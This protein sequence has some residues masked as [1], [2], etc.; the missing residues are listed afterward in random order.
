MLNLKLPLC[1]LQGRASA[2]K[3]CP[4]PG[5]SCHAA[6]AKSMQALGRLMHQ[7]EL[8]LQ[9]SVER[10][11]QHRMATSGSKSPGW[12]RLAQ[13]EE[14][15]PPERAFSQGACIRGGGT[16]IRAGMEPLDLLPLL[17]AEQVQ[18]QVGQEQPASAGPASGLLA[19]DGVVV[20]VRRQAWPTSPLRAFIPGL[21][22]G[23]TT[24]LDTQHSH[25]EA[26]TVTT[27]TWHGGLATASPPH[28]PASP[29]APPQLAPPLGPGSAPPGL[30]AQ[31]AGDALEPQ[32]AIGTEAAAA[33]P[34]V[35]PSPGHASGCMPSEPG[36]EERALEEA[37]ASAASTLTASSG[38]AGDGSCDVSR[39]C[40]CSSSGC[41]CCCRGLGEGAWA[42]SC[43]EDGSSY[44]A[45]SSGHAEG[46]SPGAPGPHASADGAR[47]RGWWQQRGVA[48][49]QAVAIVAALLLAHH[50][51]SLPAPE[52]G[53]SAWAGTCA[54]PTP[55]TWLCPLAPAQA[56]CCSVA[57]ARTHASHLYLPDTLS[58]CDCRSVGGSR[59]GVASRAA[60]YG[61]RSSC[62]LRAAH[63]AAEPSGSCVQA[64]ERLRCS[65]QG[66]LVLLTGPAE[67]RLPPH[68]PSSSSAPFLGRRPSSSLTCAAIQGLLP[69]C[70][71]DGPHAGRQAQL[72]MGPDAQPPFLLPVCPLS[73]W[74]RRATC[75]GP[76]PPSP[77][78][79]GAV[80]SAIMARAEGTQQA[81]G[82]GRPKEADG[83]ARGAGAG[84]CPLAAAV[85][86]WESAASLRSPGVSRH[87]AWKVRD[88]QFSGLEPCQPL[89]SPG[90][91]QP[92]VLQ[93]AL[94]TT[95]APVATEGPRL[96]VSGAAG[97]RRF[98]CQAGV[99]AFMQAAPPPK[100]QDGVQAQQV[101]E[102][103]GRSVPGLA[104]HTPSSLGQSP[105]LTS[106][107]THASSSHGSGSSIPRAATGGPIDGGPR[108][109]RVWARG[110]LLPT[111]LL[112]AAAA[113]TGAVYTFTWLARA[114]GCKGTTPPGPTHVVLVET[115]S[116]YWLRPNRLV[117]KM[118]CVVQPGLGRHGAS[119]SPGG[120]RAGRRHQQVAAHEGYGPS[121]HPP[122]H[123]LMR[124]LEEQVPGSS[125]GR[126]RQVGVVSGNGHRQGQGQGSGGGGGDVRELWLRSRLLLVCPPGSPGEELMA[127]GQ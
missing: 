72:R 127:R 119:G 20:V 98:R 13:A 16:E 96:G 61:N 85:Y 51:P 83:A 109:R 11:A 95:H 56:Q 6:Y 52:A 39:R 108:D 60:G 44:R 102:A 101:L 91:Q 80:T 73:H 49:M 110:R 78:P 36:W 63:P 9:G 31:T 126:A 77:A 59:A 53:P 111:L 26:Q 76:T 117:P 89:A 64:S 28:S 50:L 66:P 40:S 88:A 118:A 25:S 68:Q 23:S 5:P 46:P 32:L 1:H 45:G 27:D 87:G 19:G 3:P 38:H 103:A 105:L 48:A 113:A 22:D 120:F 4:G 18:Q 17:E 112:L 41:A 125:P 54:M 123:A 106:G 69:A 62:P 121:P 75:D 58:S 100:P 99:S 67:H 57:T 24:G 2:G 124:A 8:S 7:A 107:K 81:A 15:T 65:Q 42:A 97:G 93:P 104:C 116:H 55:A 115:G 70:T 10:H 14:L 29:T 74:L 84:I 86:S 33:T 30:E 37:R 43:Q 12:A 79:G 71:L 90:L 34:A 35:E 82:E 47:H 92:D 21:T 122:T 114:P 94:G